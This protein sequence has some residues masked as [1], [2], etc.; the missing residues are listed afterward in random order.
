MPIS[1]KWFREKTP[2]G[3]RAG[4]IEH[5]F[6]IE[7]IIFKGRTKFQKVLIFNNPLYGKVFCLDD[8]VQFSESDEFIYHEMISH[9]L[10]FSHPKPENVLII[11]GGDGGA[12]REV[13]KHPVKRVDLIELDKEIINISKRYL[14]FVCQSSFSDSRVNVHN[15][16]GEKFI[17]EHRNF[18]DIIIVDCTNPA[19][20]DI[21]SPLYSSKFYKE[22]FS[23][24]KR[25]GIMITLGA[26]FLDFD[27]FIKKYF[28]KLKNIFP[29]VAIFKFCIPSYHCGQYSFL[30]ASK[31][32]NLEKVNFKE[33]E[34]RFNQMAKNKKFNYYSPR[35]HQSSLTMPKIWKL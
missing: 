11:G 12:L 19:P 6:L 28:Q 3:K 16:P 14:P 2:L 5:S 10:L 26:S 27:D 21:S 33:I 8:V 35:I 25:D 9:P 17:K 7:K 4:N 22:A 1:K 15:L 31:K 13:L 18:Y 30:T 32:I 20:E 34:K 23:A 24:L 29:Q